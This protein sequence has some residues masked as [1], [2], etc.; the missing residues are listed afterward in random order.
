M[1]CNRYDVVEVPFPFTDKPV[2]KTRPAIV[3]SHESFQE[4]T[5]H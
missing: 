5:A 1:I 3:I 4:S 2:Y